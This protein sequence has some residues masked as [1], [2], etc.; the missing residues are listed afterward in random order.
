MS[1]VMLLQLT[2]ILWFCSWSPSKIK[3]KLYTRPE[4]NQKVFFAFMRGLFPVHEI[5][6]ALT[7]M[8]LAKRDI[9]GKHVPLLWM[10][11]RWE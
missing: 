2:R 7:A 11:R 6:A 4:H 10:V 3:C 1:L 8:Q 5:C 9:L